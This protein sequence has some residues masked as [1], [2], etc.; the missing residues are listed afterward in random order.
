MRP[1]WK[2]WAK[3]IMYQVLELWLCQYFNTIMG[4][5]SSANHPEIFQL[6][7]QKHNNY[8]DSFTKLQILLKKKSLV[9]L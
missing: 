6:K 7:D 1:L 4:Q 9:L 3:N 8:L 2:F 5:H